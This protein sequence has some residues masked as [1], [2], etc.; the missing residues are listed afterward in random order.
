MHAQPPYVA[1]S[2]HEIQLRVRGG[3][4]LLGADAGTDVGG[5]ARPGRFGLVVRHYAHQWPQRFLD[6]ELQAL[7]VLPDRLE[8]VVRLRRALHRGGHGRGARPGEARSRDA[9]P[10]CEAARLQEAVRW[11]KARTTAARVRGTLDGRWAPHVLPLWEPGCRQRALQTPA[12]VTRAIARLA[13][14]HGLSG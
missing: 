11:F 14:Q 8:A 13:A 9:A 6:L 1:L 7:A 2:H 10:A 12:E 4:P 3:L 5:P